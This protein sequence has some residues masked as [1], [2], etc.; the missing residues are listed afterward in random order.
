MIAFR[1]RRA[2]ELG[3][4]LIVHVNQDGL[5]R[6]DRAGHA[7]I[8]SP[9]RRD[10]DAGAAPGARKIRLR[11]GDRRRAAR[12]GEVARQGA[13]L[14]L[15]QRRTTAG[16]RS[17][18]GR[19]RGGCTT[20]ASG[21]ARAC[22]CSRSRTGPSWTCGSTSTRKKS[23]SFRCT[24]P[25]SARSCERDGSSSWSTTTGCRSSPA[26]AVELRACGSARS[27]ATR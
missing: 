18:S 17:V 2:Q 27:A 16:T 1:D 21:R 5:A 13:G 15:A 4:D 23:R 7:R 8:G 6:G 11:C 20:R 3:L 26:R 24:S 22:A 25:P 9:H 10:E 14:F 19:S 12:R